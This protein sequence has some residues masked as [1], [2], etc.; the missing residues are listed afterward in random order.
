MMKFITLCTGADFT[1]PLP[2]EWAAAEAWPNILS[3]SLAGKSVINRCYG[4]QGDVVVQSMNTCLEAHAV[5]P[6]LS[7]CPPWSLCRQRVWRPLAGCMG[8]AV[9]SFCQPD[10][11]RSGKQHIDRCCAISAPNV[12]PTGLL[13]AVLR[14]LGK[15][16]VPGQGP[17]LLPM[18]DAHFEGRCR[19]F[20][21][22]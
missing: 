1:G 17:C 6:H 10:C 4:L 21:S 11:T 8:P 15:C 5:S 19:S 13:P 9:R 22:I 7:P 18:G 2:V 16:Q 14:R 12:H 3:L 20:S